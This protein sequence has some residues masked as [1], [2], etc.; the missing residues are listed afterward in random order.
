MPEVMSRRDRKKAATRKSLSDAASR[1]FRERGY[2]NVTVADVA[3]E[4]DTAVTTLFAHF[5]D[6]KQALIFG[7]S[8]NRAAALAAA[9]RERP[10]GTD[11][12]DA[13]ERFIESRGPFGGVVDDETQK[14]LD[15][16]RVTPVL[17]EYARRRWVEC[18]D[19]LTEVLLEELSPQ[20]ED[21]VRPLARFILEAPQLAGRSATPRV[22]L[23]DIFARLRRGWS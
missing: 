18:E 11:A 21:I 22:A 8:E 6:G 14:V 1:L 23:E 3:A 7:G 15:I 13:I 20:G 9:V 19:V 16:I 4:A 17:V 2:D 5:P 12:L 10:T